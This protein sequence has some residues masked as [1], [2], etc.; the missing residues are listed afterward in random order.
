M[1]KLITNQTDYILIDNANKKTKPTKRKVTIT[2][3]LIKESKEK[4]EKEIIKEITQAFENENLILPWCKKI[5][6]ISLE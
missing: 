1:Y 5:E 2:F 4:N 6:S 3:S